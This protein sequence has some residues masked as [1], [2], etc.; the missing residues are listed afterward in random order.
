MLVVNS[1]IQ[2]IRTI[3]EQI[4]EPNISNKEIEQIMNNV[5]LATEY[6]QMRRMEIK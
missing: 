4:R 2:K 3:P 5:L 1:L 6:E